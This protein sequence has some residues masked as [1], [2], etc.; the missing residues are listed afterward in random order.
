MSASVLLPGV[1]K[2]VSLG[3]GSVGVIFKLFA[4]DTGGSFALVEHPVEPGALAPPHRH[5]NE[6]EYIP[7]WERQ[8][9]VCHR[10]RGP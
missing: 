5:H 9:G 2:A 8:S 1:G 6:D 3:P 4:A 7:A 10:K